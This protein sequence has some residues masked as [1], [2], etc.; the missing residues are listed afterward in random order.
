MRLRNSFD[1][2]I[3]G[4]AAVLETDN[5]GT[6]RAAKIVLNAV[7]SKPMEVPKAAAA[8]LGTDL[9]ESALDAAAEEAYAAGKPLDNTSGSIPY[10]KR[11]LRVFA[12]RT[13]EACL[14]ATDL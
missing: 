12:R 14:V 10:R 3:L 1:F 5:D 13:L 7:A 2:P 6:C 4:I 9:N 11:M 8:L